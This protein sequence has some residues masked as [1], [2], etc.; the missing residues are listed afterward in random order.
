MQR[1][2]ILASGRVQGVGFRNFAC[3]IGSSLSLT[4]YA[5]NMPD[6]SVEIFTEGEPDEI[7]SFIRRMDVRFPFGI[8]VAKLEIVDK[9]EA[10]S[11]EFPSFSIRL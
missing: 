5:K 9:K 2:K 6:G 8:S 4:G 11:R 3:R 10:G 1:V 7:S